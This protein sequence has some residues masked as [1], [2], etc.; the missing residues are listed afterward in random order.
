MTYERIFRD[1]LRLLVDRL[2]ATKRYGR[3]HAYIGKTLL[4]DPNAFRMLRPDGS[5]GDGYP[6]FGVHVYDR[7][8]GTLFARWPFDIEPWP[9]EVR[10]VDLH[11]VRPAGTRG[12]AKAAAT[13]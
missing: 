8:V 9:S 6:T 2:A 7:L 5:P 1:N 13:V 12:R 11:E 4:A 3:T 10:P